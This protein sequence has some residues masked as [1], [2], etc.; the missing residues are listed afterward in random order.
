MAMG[1][2]VRKIDFWELIMPFIIL[3]LL[4]LVLGSRSKV[5]EIL[6]IEAELYPMAPCMKSLT[7]FK[8]PSAGISSTLVHQRTCLTFKGKQGVTCKV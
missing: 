8:A 1:F 3:F 5:N 7:G 6:Y 4:K 2:E